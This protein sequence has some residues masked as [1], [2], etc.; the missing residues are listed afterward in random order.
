ML[1]ETIPDLVNMGEYHEAINLLEAIIEPDA[2]ILSNLSRINELLGYFE[3]ALE[4]ARQ[5]LEIAGDDLS[6]YISVIAYAYSQ[7]RLFNFEEALSKLSQINKL[8]TSPEWKGSYYNIRGLIYWKEGDLEL[9]EREFRLGLTLR[10]QSGDWNKISYSLNNLGNTYLKLS[11]YNQADSYFTEALKIRKELGHKPAIAASYNSFGR[12]NDALRNYNIAK[13]FH[14]NSL[15]LWKQ[16]GNDQFIAKSYRYL[17]INAA[18]SKNQHQA[19]EYF[20]LSDN[21]FSQIPNITDLRVNS[22]LKQQ[23]L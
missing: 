17:G 5:A 7:W 23:Y 9:A 16:V 4:L 12:L 1:D 20:T 6:R 15:D 18:L 21:L 19:L 11:D 8:S 13:D 22:N 3:K 10:R 2:I 14:I